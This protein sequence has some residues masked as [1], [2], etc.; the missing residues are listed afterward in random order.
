M[1]GISDWR[2]LVEGPKQVLFGGHH[3]SEWTV[4]RRTCRMF[5][6]ANSENTNRCMPASPHHPAT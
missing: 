6:A 3:F 1:L 5:S 4:H 2:P